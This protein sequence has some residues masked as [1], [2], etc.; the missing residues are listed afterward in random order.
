MLAAALVAEAAAQ[1]I[2]LIPPGSRES[3]SPASP[4]PGSTAPGS[5]APAQANVPPVETPAPPAEE[6]RPQAPAEGSASPNGFVI[7]PLQAPDPSSAGLLDDGNGGL[8]AGMW[9]GSTRRQAMQ[10]LGTLPAPVPAPALRELQR[11]LLLTT[12]QVPP[13]E[14]GTPSLLGLRIAQLYE[15][16]QIDAARQLATPKP[17]E[18]KDTVFLQIPVDTA[19]LQNDLPRACELISQGLREDGAAYWQKASVLCRYDAKD[20]AGGD[21][22]LSLWR[23]SGGDDPSF[24]ALAAALRGDSRVKLDKLGSAVSPLHLAMLR[25][26]GRTVPK[27]MLEIASPAVLAALS[28]YDK[29]DADLR[30]A[31][32]EAA[33]RFGALPPEKLGEA[34]AALEIPDAQRAAL[35]TGKDK[36]SRSAAA[37]YQAI[38]GTADAKARAD[39]LRRAFELA[40]TRDLLFPTAM[41][42]KPLLAEIPADDSTIAA[43]PAIIRFALAAGDTGIAR[44]WYNTLLTISPERAGDAAAQAW[45]LLL[46]SGAE[47]EWRDS[48]FDAWV[49]AQEKLPAPERNARTA[50][51]LTLAEGAG[52]AV[53][54]ERWD[55]LL[56]PTAATG[57][58]SAAPVTIWR[59]LARA[60]QAKARAETVA[61]TLALLG[62]HG[63]EMADAQTLATA[64]NALRSVDLTEEARQIALEAALLRDF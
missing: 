25:A 17:P 36:S 11:R 35:L 12:A 21:L 63:T 19:L 28:G 18:L 37:L 8:G 31:A 29:A 43:A 49:A 41:V 10:A 58:R 44:L 16:G 7:Q 27:D 23:D 47:A 52:V 5:T 46:V 57:T 2:R 34:Y 53:P 26:S 13:G 54:A 50:L 14:G 39:L 59:N 61:L 55:S 64:L 45:P 33:A 30:L 56:A 42:L 48:R 60:S 24:N 22:A 3:E 62:P 1:P 40:Q 32:A 51:L 20:I 6:A 38:R 15:L 4:A 9:Q